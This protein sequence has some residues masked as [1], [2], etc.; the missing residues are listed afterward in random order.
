MGE[1]E[2]QAARTKRGRGSDGGRQSGLQDQGRIQ[3]LVLVF[4]SV[5]KWFSQWMVFSFHPW[6]R[7][8]GAQGEREREWWQREEREFLTPPLFFP[9]SSPLS[10]TQ[11]RMKNQRGI[12]KFLS[13]WNKWNCLFYSIPHPWS[14]S[15]HIYP[16]TSHRERER[17]S[18]KRER[19][20]ART[21]FMQ[22]KCFILD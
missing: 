12:N 4:S 8:T 18:E 5:L 3:A 2:A 17:E 6:M 13:K 16:E 21:C 22:M 9:Y 7:F 1:E 15:C 11:W 10:D 14:V 20:S 19:G